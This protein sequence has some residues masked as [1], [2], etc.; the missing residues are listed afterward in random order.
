MA[1]TMIQVQSKNISQIGY[2]TA[3]HTLRILFSTGNIYEYDEVPE[4]IFRMFVDAV[5]KGAF[6]K[7]QIKFTYKYKK[8]C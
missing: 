4:Q 2:D 6:F 1:I 7:S 5:S 3:G 8:V